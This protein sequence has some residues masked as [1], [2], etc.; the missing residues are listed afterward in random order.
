VRG[1]WRNFA[2]V[3]GVTGCA[4]AGAV[5]WTATLAGAV[6]ANCIDAPC[7]VSFSMTGSAQSWTVP[8]GVDHITAAVAGGN[9]GGSGNTPL[10]GLGGAVTATVPV[11][12][13]DQLSIVVGAA[14]TNGSYGAVS[15]PVAAYGGGGLGSYIDEGPD[16]FSEG[17]GAAVR[18]SSTSRRTTPC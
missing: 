9:G 16:G 5:G 7:T 12:A 3:A 1:S 14:G 15:A 6:P 13:G 11:T 8:A 17:S 18:S 4:V 2:V 10:G